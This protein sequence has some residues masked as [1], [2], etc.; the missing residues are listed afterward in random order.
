MT[1]AIDRA[2]MAQQGPFAQTDL[3]NWIASRAI[4]LCKEA[5][6]ESVNMD[7]KI[8]ELRALF[9][10]YYTSNIVDKPWQFVRKIQGIDGPGANLTWNGFFEKLVADFEE[11]EKN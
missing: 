7:S 2:M 9:S 5:E 11:Q 6:I 4:Y 8:P 1:T 10:V 3:E